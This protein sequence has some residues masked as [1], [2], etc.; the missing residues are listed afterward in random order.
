MR[1]A[2][3]AKVKASARPGLERRR[4]EVREERAPGQERHALAG[5]CASD[6][7]RRVRIGL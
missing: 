2:T 5:R 7:P 1:Q 4:D 6:G 3:T